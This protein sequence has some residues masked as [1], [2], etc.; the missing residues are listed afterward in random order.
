ML[1]CKPASTPADLSA[2]FDDTGPPVADPTLYRSLAGALQYLT[3]TRPDLTYAVQQVCL[4]MHDPKEPYFSALKRILRYVRGTLHHGLQLYSFSNRD[5][6][7]YSDADWAGCPVT[8]RSTSSYCVFLAHNLLS[9]SSKHQSTISRSSAKAE[10][11]GVANAV[12][13]TCWIRNLLLELHYSPHKAI[14]VYCDN[15]SAV[16]MSSN[17]V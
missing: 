12:V 6:Y 4:Y 17:P 10:Y 8:R 16:Y 11:R 7:T 5:I 3:F 15:V 13:E 1:N 14:I 9:W 2:K